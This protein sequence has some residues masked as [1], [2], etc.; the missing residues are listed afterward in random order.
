MPL[1]FAEGDVFPEFELEDHRGQKITC[2]SLMDGKPTILVF[3]RGP[4]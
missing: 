1:R 2:D 3:F 4:W